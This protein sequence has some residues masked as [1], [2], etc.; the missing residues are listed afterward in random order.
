MGLHK[1]CREYCLEG[2]VWSPRIGHGTSVFMA[3]FT[4]KATVAEPS[5]KPEK[6]EAPPKP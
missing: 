6:S 2:A 3:L 4:F 1:I 5:S